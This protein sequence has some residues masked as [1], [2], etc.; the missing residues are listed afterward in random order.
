MK[1]RKALS[2]LI[3]LFLFPLVQAHP[4][5]SSKA[6]TIGERFLSS[7]W[8]GTKAQS[9]T[10]NLAYVAEDSLSRPLWYAFSMDNSGFVLV[11]AEDAMQPVLAYSFTSGFDPDNIP[12]VV[13]EWLSGY[14][15]QIEACRKGKALP[16][17]PMWNALETGVFQTKGVQEVQ[18]LVTTKW[19]QDGT[20]KK[21]QLCIHYNLYCPYDTAAEK[22]TLTGCVATA[23][24]Q[25]M[26]Y[27][28]YPA[29]GAGAYTYRHAVYG[30]ISADF[31]KFNLANS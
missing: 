7:Q 15:V 8:L 20:K 26:R 25:L 18:P 22:N 14:G 5:D 1:L 19:G 17:D 4:V 2:V 9:S 6:R 16:A 30:T 10:L 13:M 29:H 21:E 27:W 23:M 31:E 12:P 11:S 24:A 3:S 28:R